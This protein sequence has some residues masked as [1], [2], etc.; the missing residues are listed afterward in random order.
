MEL[1]G[2]A[3]DMDFISA[4]LA[5]SP[6]QASAAALRSLQGLHK[7][8]MVTTLYNPMGGK[9]G[10]LRHEGGFNVLGIPKGPARQ[11]IISRFAGGMI[12]GFDFNAI[13]YR[14]IV[15]TIGGEVKKLY[16]GAEDFHERTASF[17]FKQITPATRSAI[18][19]LSYI[20]IYG[21]SEET[22][23]EKTGWTLEQVKQ[24]L[25]LLD[26]KIAPIKEFRSK[27]WME[28]QQTGVVVAPGGRR[29]HTLEGDNEG[30][31]IGLYAQTYSSWVF[32]QAVIQVQKLLRGLESKLIFTVHDELVIDTHPAE[33]AIMEDVR[34]V[35]EIDGH[36]VKMKK[37]S[38]YGSL[39]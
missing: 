6:D 16:E 17:V 15:N 8:G 38:S 5:E 31:V 12:T 4:A 37:G 26:K 22:L 39:E 27:L 36:K 11:A 13:D 20:Y 10:R 29:V 24:V 1:N 32:E 2:I 19:Y 18:K 7:D 30:K 14:C 28:A 23:V 3:I 9:T 25:E 34:R 35:M 21:G 33:V